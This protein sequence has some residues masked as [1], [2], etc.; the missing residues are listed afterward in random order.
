MYRELFFMYLIV[1][2]VDMQ[3]R[4]LFPPGRASLWRLGFGTPVNENDNSLSC[5][6]LKHRWEV[7]NGRC[8]VCGDPWDS[9]PR[10]HEQGGKFYS[11][12][13]SAIFEAGKPAT[14]SLDISN[15][16]GGYF[17]FRVCVKDNTT[18]EV[19]QKCLDEGQLEFLNHGLRFTEVV[20]GLNEVQVLLS[21]KLICE[22]CLL[23]WKYTTVNIVTVG[24]N[25]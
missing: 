9:I 15:A 5:G 10:D 1:T 11:D 21:E 4:M 13:T 17:E 23:Q 22:S 24:S 14:F 19:S 12:V 6:G 2:G 25:V 16:N 18:A 7:N 3:G 20:E 8:G